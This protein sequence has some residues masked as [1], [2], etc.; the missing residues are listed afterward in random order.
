MKKSLPIVCV[1]RFLPGCKR[2]RRGV[3]ET[4]FANSRGSFPDAMSVHICA[5]SNGVCARSGRSSFKCMRKQDYSKDF[6][7]MD[8]SL[9]SFRLLDQRLRVWTFF[10]SCKRRTLS[11]VSTDTRSTDQPQVTEELFS[12]MGS[13]TRGS[14][15]DTPTTSK[16]DPGQIVRRPLAISSPSEH[17]PTSR[18]R[19]Q[20][21]SIDR[22]IQEYLQAH[23]EVGHRPK[24]LEWHHMA[25]CH[26]H[27]YLLNE[28]H[29]HLINQISETTM[30][31][32]LAFIV[33]TPTTRGILRSASTTE[34]FARSA[35]AFFGWLLERG[36]LACS[37][38]SEEA[39][40]RTAVPLPRFVSSTTFDQVMRAGVPRKGKAPEATRTALR[41]QA[42]LWVLFDTGITVSELC[43]LRVADLDHHTGSLRVRG[44]G[45]E[46]RLM[47]L[48]A[49]CL[50]HLRVY[51]KQMEPTTKKGLTRR[52]A[53]GAPLFPT[54]QRTS[55][56]CWLDTGLLFGERP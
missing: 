53:G 41:D 52:Q 1:S 4:S 8:L 5:P 13:E 24:T 40:P 54:S 37:P 10:A 9:P 2:A 7:V 31:N 44:K 25:L 23:R 33:Q 27:Q 18:E 49:I 15:S 20:R 11:Q 14:I 48:G 45:G 22:A 46:E 12:H 47:P 56:R 19:S 35:R 55:S 42:L 30:R 21:L 3:A 28:C 39:F 36:T 16:R 29:L 32:W 50:S 51:L 34:T 26:L 6:R 43:A 38:M 17:D